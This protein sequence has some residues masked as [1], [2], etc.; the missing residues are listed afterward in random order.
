MGSAAKMI[1]LRRNQHVHQLRRGDHDNTYLQKS[2]NKHTEA[3]FEFMP[4]A[5]CAPEWCLAIEQFYINRFNATNKSIGYNLSSVAGSRLGLKQSEEAKRKMSLAQ[6]GLKRTLSPEVLA[7]RRARMLGVKRPREVVEKMIATKKANFDPLFGKGVSERNRARSPELLARIYA[8]TNTPEAK[9]TRLAK[10]K[11]RVLPPD[12]IKKIT[13]ARWSGNAREK[14]SKAMSGRKLSK[15]HVAAL[16]AASALRGPVPDWVRKKLSDSHKGY[17]MPQAQKE[18]I[19]EANIGR[20]FS[21]ATMAKKRASAS[22]PE[23]REKQR[24]IALAQ[25]AA[26]KNNP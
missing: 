15:E 12:V 17:V 1:S 5:N 26:R 19:R 24:Q 10:L 11:A 22:S 14:M 18:K 25:W 16:K 9:A 20:K 8:A 4:L 13:A 6:T 3:N 7:A 21:A 23:F 2:W